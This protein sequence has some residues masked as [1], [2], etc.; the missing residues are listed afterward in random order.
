[1]PVFEYEVVDRS[2]AIGRGRQQAEDQAEL[3]QRLRDRGQLVV[4]LRAA[5]APRA[6]PLRQA[7]QH[8]FRRVTGRVRLATLVLFTGQL[9]AWRIGGRSEE[10]TSELQSR[11]HLVCRLL[12]EKKKQ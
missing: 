3:M 9:G 12:L 11:L 8:S 2:G 4:S 6:A 1:M 10:H 5:D 7:L